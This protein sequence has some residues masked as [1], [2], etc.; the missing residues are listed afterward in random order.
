MW[1]MTVLNFTCF[2]IVLIK[3]I[4]FSSQVPSPCKLRL[5]FYENSS[6][7]SKQQ[8]KKLSLQIQE[9]SRTP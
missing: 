3:I 7:M 4:K 6:T 5:K 2:C 9:I 8:L 1:Q